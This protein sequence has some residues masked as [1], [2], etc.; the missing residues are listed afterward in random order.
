[1]TIEPYNDTIAASLESPISRGY[2]LRMD[3]SSHAEAMPK[4]NASKVRLA[5]RV[6]IKRTAPSQSSRARTC[7]KCSLVRL[8]F[9]ECLCATIAAQYCLYRST[10]AGTTTYRTWRENPG[11]SQSSGATPGRPFPRARAI[12]HGISLTP[13][14]WSSSL[15]YGRVAANVCQYDGHRCAC[16][17]Y[18]FFARRQGNS[19]W[20]RDWARVARRCDRR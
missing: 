17:R 9:L 5:P 20:T 12:D 13:C 1:M 19:A 6:C 3:C 16:A 8:G 15:S 10:D 11:L 14:D 4:G 18:C 7:A 2:K